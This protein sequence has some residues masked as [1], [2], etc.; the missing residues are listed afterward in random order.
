MNFEM[1]MEKERMNGYVAG[2]EEG[3]VEVARSMIRDKMP[4]DVVAKYSRL[5]LSELQAL[6][7]ECR[8]MAS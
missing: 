3:R 7:A 5:P 1:M 2:M 8:A 4:L 6:E